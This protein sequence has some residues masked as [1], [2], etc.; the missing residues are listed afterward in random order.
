MDGG[1]GRDYR[2]A[3][4]VATSASGLQDAI[5]GALGRAQRHLGTVD[6]F[7]VTDLRGTVV[8]G[9][10]GRWQVG[11]TV[12]YRPAPCQPGR[13][14]GAAGPVGLADTDRRE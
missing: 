3:E 10:V 7:H 12:G 14:P 9:R 5:E 2:T 13:N 8:E 4:L 1:D 11:L 6:W